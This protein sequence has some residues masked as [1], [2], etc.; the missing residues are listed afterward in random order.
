MRNTNFWSQQGLWIH[1]GNSFVHIQKVVSKD[2]VKNVTRFDFDKTN[3][4]LEALQ[5]KQA[6]LVKGAWQLENISGTRITPTHSEAFSKSELP[7]GF[8]FEPQ[9]LQKKMQTDALQQSIVSLWKNINYRQ[10]SGLTTQNLESAFWQ[11]LMQPL[12]TIVMICLG[13]PFIFGS[14]RSASMSSRILTGIIVGFI[15]YVIN[16]FLG[17][18]TMVY[19]WPAWIAGISPTILFLL[20]FAFLLTRSQ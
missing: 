19:Q 10:A 4:L 6:V 3:H 13:I 16:Q 18:F 9:L 11:R 1:Q 14:L 8:S 2:E 17:P 12:T 7:L 15:F 20:I 5:A